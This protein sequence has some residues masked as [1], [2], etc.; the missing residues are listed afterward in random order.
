MLP[1]AEA[2]RR[3]YD[4][5]LPASALAI[6]IDDGYADNLIVAAPI[7]E[8]LKLPATVSAA[9]RSAKRRFD[10]RRADPGAAETAGRRLRSRTKRQKTP[11]LNGQTK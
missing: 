5:A 4:G 7:L 10:R 3:L 1:L 8:R 9:E 6:T 11:R 2:T